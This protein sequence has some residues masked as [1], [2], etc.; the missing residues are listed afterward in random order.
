MLAKEV[1]LFTAG[2]NPTD[3]GTYVF[4]ARSAEA[5][6]A[7]WSK[8][9]HLGMVDLE[10]LSLDKKAP[11]YD[12]DARAWYRLEVRDGELWATQLS[13]TPDGEDRIKTGKQKY[14]SPAFLYDPETMEILE[15][16]NVALTAVP[17]THDPQA[18]AAASKNMRRATMAADGKGGADGADGTGGGLEAIAKVLGLGDDA[19]LT[20]L[21]TKIGEL[22]TALYGDDDDDDEPDGD[23]AAEMSAAG[24]PPPP[25]PNAPPADKKTAKMAASKVLTVARRSA[26]RALLSHTGAK[27]TKDGIAALES[28]KTIV[29]D[30][31]AQRAELAKKQAQL[32]ANERAELIGKMV[33]LGK[34]VP[35]T[36]WADEARTAPAEPWASMKI[37]A[38][39]DRVAKLSA[40]PSPL[41]RAPLAGSKAAEAAYGLTPAQLASC[42]RLNIRPEDYVAKLSKF[43]PEQRSK[44]GV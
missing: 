43:T 31:S 41:A 15:I 21:L 4:S 11:N 33:T 2:E 27:T 22:K 36:A 38:L 34:E 35:A 17:A 40:G 30:V 13:Y 44:M 5:V 3:N 18:F 20:D 42:S 7:T 26:H 29:A 1:R 23:E 10:H 9:G 37:E 6:M 28:W 25:P 12:P 32:E 39:R 19:S 8:Q 14:P 16:H 24:A